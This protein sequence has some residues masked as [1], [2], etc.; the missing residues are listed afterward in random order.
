M[1]SA[2]W[3]ELLINPLRR[4][5]TN[6]SARAEYDD[7]RLTRSSKNKKNPEKH[8]Q[9]CIEAIVGV[10]LQEDVMRR[11]IIDVAGKTD[12]GS[13]RE[14]N[15][16]ACLS[17]IV[18]DG[19]VQGIR[20]V[21]AISD[22]MGGHE[23]GDVA[24][25]I[26]VEYLE[27]LFVRGNDVAFCKDLG[28]DPFDYGAVLR[29]VLMT[30]NRKI[31]D[32]AVTFNLFKTMGCTCVVGLIVCGQ[33]RTQWSLV[34]GSVGDSRCYLIRGSDILLATEDDSLVWQLY[35][36]KEISYA[37]MRYHPKRNVLTQALGI[38]EVIQPQIC[39]IGL[40]SGDVVLL[41]S[42]GLHTVM[43]EKEIRQ[44]VAR[45]STPGEAAE[46]LVNGANRSGSKDNIS[47]SVAYCSKE[48]LL[49]GKKR[50]NVSRWTMR[51][52]AVLVT[53]IALLLLLN[54]NTEL[55]A[56]QYSMAVKDLPSV[57]RKDSLVSIRF[58]VEPYGTVSEN[59]EAYKIVRIVDYQR[60]ESVR[61][62]DLPEPSRNE[63][64]L[65][66]R[67][68]RASIHQMRL[69][70]VKDEDQKP[71]SV[72]VLSFAVSNPPALT[73]NQS[74]PPRTERPESSPLKLSRGPDGFLQVRL[75][76]DF[77]LSGDLIAQISAGGIV[78]VV[79]LSRKQKVIPQ[80][81]SLEYR[82][83]EPVQV[84]LSPTGK[85]FQEILR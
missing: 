79:S 4:P 35:K 46:R 58:S 83:G 71:L 1:R 32:R 17:A 70:L 36:R 21:L 33:D 15:E 50:S 76:K 62:V 31:I 55:P 14:L 22:G 52:A 54:S 25:K 85:S 20:A 81:T 28:I 77:D 57:I 16:D 53:G 78:E 13:K 63:F 26:A 73:V 42:D 66:C 48:P 7:I 11:M 84:T 82:R 9:Q 74:P 65:P 2:V 61:L 10:H 27:H 44:I 49:I 45:A 5:R 68:E 56:T 34:L 41:S 38:Q 24:S 80:R 59:R 23:A 6:V 18:R 72:D 19:G 60:P 29:E 12:I 3:A 75:S 64:L 37:E 43:S 40:E 47:V 30:I 51:G 69:L 8:A 67:F 39:S